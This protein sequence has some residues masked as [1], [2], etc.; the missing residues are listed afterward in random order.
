MTTSDGVP[1]IEDELD[2]GEEGSRPG[3]TAQNDDAKNADKHWLW[4]NWQLLAMAAMLSFSVC[5]MFIGNISQ[6]G[7][8]SVEYFCSGS[9][10]LSLV[11][12]IARR[13]WSLKNGI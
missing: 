3:A 2:L 13:E 11:Y 7:L 4:D 10:L 8:K 5:N 9:L 1:V 6:M 12:F